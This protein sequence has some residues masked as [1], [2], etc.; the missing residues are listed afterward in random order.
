MCVIESTQTKAKIS[1]SNEKTAQTNTAVEPIVYINMPADYSGDIWHV[2]AALVVDCR[3]HVVF[4]RQTKA[5]TSKDMTTMA[6]ARAF[7]LSIGIPESRM[8][9]IDIEPF[10]VSAKVA[11]TKIR[12]MALDVD[13]SEIKRDIYTAR[14]HQE[15]AKAA[16]GQPVHAVY[17]S[18]C[19]WTDAINAKS[20][21]DVLD[22]IKAAF[23]RD[24]EKNH[25]D[26]AAAIRQRIAEVT[27]GAAGFV[28][29]NMRM[30]NYH[31]E[32]N[33]SF[34]IY[35]AAAATVNSLKTR[36][37][38]LI[39]VGSFNPKDK[40]HA[41]ED[42]KWM[43]DLVN[44]VVDI[45]NF[46]R[47]P[48]GLADMQSVAYFWAQ[49]ASLDGCIG[50]LGGRSG[51]SDIAGLMGNRLL[52]WTICRPVDPGYQRQH[53]MVGKIMS[54]ID[55]DANNPKY[56]SSKPHYT[57]DDQWTK[58]DSALR[59]AI[60]H[61]IEK[62]PV[63]GPHCYSEL[64]SSTE[65][66]HEMVASP[67]GSLKFCFE[68]AALALTKIEAAKKA[69]NARSGI[70]S[71]YEIG[72]ADGVGMNCMLR[73]LYQVKHGKGTDKTEKGEQDIAEMRARLMKALDVESDEQLDLIRH[74]APII[75]E[76]RIR[77]RL[78]R[79]DSDGNLHDTGMTIGNEGPTFPLLYEGDGNAGHFTPLY[80]KP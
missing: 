39:R 18:T 35:N 67:R 44:E 56:S 79:I 43:K 53:L 69:Y 9:V 30:A 11:D 1:R 75:A 71:R 17:S 74:G 78:I 38:R 57:L 32:D 59:K 13:E 77:V 4:T 80:H 26:E 16:K 52:C 33:T 3:V 37:I 22:A 23:I 36:K 61:W 27:A 47:L 42:G 70:Q 41:S 25:P 50:V 55:C 12:E 28:F 29:V 54:L 46:C 7:F 5:E 62:K 64:M 15:R 63:F 51:S 14:S 60:L 76:F 24:F 48:S 34:W 65:E 73:S 49:V 72:F 45:Y 21:A 19:I 8:E 20:R 68:S 66:L 40:T 2:A 31:P 6:K 10:E 58:V